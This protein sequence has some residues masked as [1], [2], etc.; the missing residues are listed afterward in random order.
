M[1]ERD[2]LTS[3]DA[4]IADLLR[5]VGAREEPSSAIAAQVQAAVHAE[6]GRMIAAR[7]RRRVSAWALAASVC[8]MAVG[9][10][11]TVRYLDDDDQGKSIAT[12]VRTEGQILVARGEDGWTRIEAGRPIAV[13]D[14]IRSD[15]RAAFV[16]DTGAAVRL[17]RG[18]AVR[19]AADDRFALEAG[20]VYVDS[21]VGRNSSSLTIST[22]AGSVR[23]IGTQYEV[24]IRDDGIDVSVRE[25]RV[26][27]ESDHGSNVAGAGERLTVSL[28]GSVQR[29]RIS[30]S[31]EQWSWA[32]EIAPT[33]AIENVSLAAFLQWVARETGKPLIY[34][35]ERARSL[36]A[37]EILHGSIDGLPPDAAL[38]AVL[39]STSLH[40]DE[41]KPGVILIG[42]N[43]GAP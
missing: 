22:S 20:A 29:S 28:A 30:P 39:S 33:Y 9:A 7:R 11:I 25:G 13:G 8:A 23:H 34:E 36:A 4:E 41:T 15:A 18:T 37:G 1:T 17:D 24:R 19:V 40:R 43:D 35:S 38:A 5:S 31:D 42:V 6:W 12:L 27:I 2:D 16:L 10:A 14:S 3:D 32:T 21:G 26:M